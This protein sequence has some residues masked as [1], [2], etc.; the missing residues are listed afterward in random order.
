MLGLREINK[1][2]NFPQKTNDDED[3]GDIKKI[4]F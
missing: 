3:F 4:I 2:Q 1:V